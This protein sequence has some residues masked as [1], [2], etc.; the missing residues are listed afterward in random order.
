MLKHLADFVLLVLLIANA[1]KLFYIALTV[2]I[3]V[4]LLYGFNTAHG[5][6]Y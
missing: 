1:K 2:V 4:L 6:V 3:F 5:V